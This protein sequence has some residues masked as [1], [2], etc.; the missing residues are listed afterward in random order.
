LSFVPPPSLKSGGEVRRNPLPVIAY[1]KPALGEGI[2]L[3]RVG[4]KASVT[5][6]QD[7]TTGSNGGSNGVLQ[8]VL[9]SVLGDSAVYWLD[10]RSGGP[11]ESFYFVKESS[12]KLRDDQEDLKRLSGQ[13]NIT[14][15]E[16][17]A[18]QGGGTELRVSSAELAISITYGV[19]AD[20]ARQRVLRQSHRRAVES[21]WL[22]EKQLVESG[23]PGQQVDWSI[24]ERVELLT[25]GRVN[26]FI[27]S[28]L[29]SVYEYPQLA[30]DASN[31]VFRRDEAKRKR[32][33]KSRHQ[34]RH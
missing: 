4:G 1:R 5:L 17:G 14:L 8:D 11:Q 25:N 24:E 19:D 21:A 33:N 29:H 30:D 15:I 20:T 34:P 28:D 31:I 9:G 10:V 7:T 22:R 27:G 16:N 32:R 18:E 12:A 13:F 26:G 3:S 6:V 2:L 23:L